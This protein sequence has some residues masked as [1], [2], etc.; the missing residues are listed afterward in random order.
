MEHDAYSLS[1]TF[2]I[3]SVIPEYH[4]IFICNLMVY[5]KKNIGNASWRL[6]VFDVQG[7]I[8]VNYSLL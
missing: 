6:G 3:K 7:A 5:K 8:F 1:E 2:I 4:Y